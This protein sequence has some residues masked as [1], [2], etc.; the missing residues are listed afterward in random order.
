MVSL[1]QD[2][3]RL[4]NYLTDSGCSFA[5][6]NKDIGDGFYAANFAGCDIIEMEAKYTAGRGTSVLDVKEVLVTNY[7]SVV[8]GVLPL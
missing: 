3:I 2:Q 4:A 6:S 8:P 5:Y 7:D 1:E